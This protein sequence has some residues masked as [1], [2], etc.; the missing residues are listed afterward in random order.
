MPN[1]GSAPIIIGPLPNPLKPFGL[2][3]VA[4]MDEDAISESATTGVVVSAL[5]DCSAKMNEPAT[6][7]I[8]MTESKA[9]ALVF[10]FISFNFTSYFQETVSDRLL[11]DF[12]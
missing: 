5:A 3:S 9:K 2:L 8:T 10:A 7:V 4:F 1:L 11:R 6:A 12:S